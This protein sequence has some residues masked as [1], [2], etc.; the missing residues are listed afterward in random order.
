MEEDKKN[1]L[2]YLED[3]LSGLWSHKGYLF[4][5]FVTGWSSLMAVA[6]MLGA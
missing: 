5:G 2:N 3:A 4:L 1:V 6:F